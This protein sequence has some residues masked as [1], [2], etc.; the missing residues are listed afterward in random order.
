MPVDLASLLASAPFWAGIATVI[1]AL[2]GFLGGRANSKK[3]LAEAAK[4]QAETKK[5]LDDQAT[6]AENRLHD[7]IMASFKTLADLYEKNLDS[8][9]S[10]IE[11]MDREINELRA[12]NEHLSKTVHELTTD[13]EQL[14]RT[15]DDLRR[16]I[17]RLIDALRNAGNGCAEDPHIAPL[18]TGLDL[19]KN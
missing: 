6:T 16:H 12:E 7:Q 13:K 4:L 11:N 8:M 1:G 5:L 2:G 14:R 9:K 19:P 10:T 15:V 18:L 17:E 3:T